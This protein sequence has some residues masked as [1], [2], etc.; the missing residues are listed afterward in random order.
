MIRSRFGLHIYVL[1]LNQEYGHPLFWT[2][3]EHK[4]ELRGTTLLYDIQRDIYN[5]ES[6]YK[7]YVL[8]FIYRYKDICG[9]VERYSL[10]LYKRLVA[11]VMA[12]S[13]T[14]DFGCEP[15][16]IPLADILNH[17]STKNNAKLVFGDENVEVIAIKDINKGDE[18]L[19][20]FGKLGN[21]ELLQ[22]YGY[23]DK[24]AN[25]YDTLPILVNTFLD[26]MEKQEKVSDSYFQAKITLLNKTEIA[27]TDDYFLFD[28][29]GLRRGPDL[30]QMLKILFMPEDEFDNSPKTSWESTGFFLSEIV[31]E[32]KII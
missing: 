32:I 26:M 27:H 15:N 20:T 24:E 14:E 29:N 2:I 28:R 11:F 21:A 18:I 10:G 17:H 31:A 30:I 22:T 19:N 6:E 12:Y 7:Q 25:V 3:E 23:A 9:N 16:M 13:F 5:I 8:P 1:F 4:D